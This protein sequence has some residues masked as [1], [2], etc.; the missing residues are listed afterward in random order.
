MKHCTFTNKEQEVWQIVTAMNRAWVSGSPELVAGF[1]HDNVTI[2]GP[3]L[4][5]M[6]E[7]KE[8]C[9]QSYKDFAGRAVIHY[10]SEHSPFVRLAFPAAVAGY[11]YEIRYTMNDVLH[12]ETG[13]DLLVCIAKDG[14]WKVLCRE[15]LFDENH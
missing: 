7:G 9:T 15:V 1:L 5:V 12:E 13:Q 6:A 2:L 11:R 3:G 4:A 14:C 8:A 10:F